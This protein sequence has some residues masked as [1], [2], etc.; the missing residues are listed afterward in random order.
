MLI[1]IWDSVESSF[2][3]YELLLKGTYNNTSLVSYTIGIH[4]LCNYID[5]CDTE[6]VAVVSRRSD[7]V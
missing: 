3:K 4:I 1:W 2:H 5:S 7:I 6:A